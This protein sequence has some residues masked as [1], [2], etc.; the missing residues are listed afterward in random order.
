MHADWVGQGCSMR[1]LRGSD[2]KSG[3][4]RAENESV[5][6]SRGK[7]HKQTSRNCYCSEL[8][9]FPGPALLDDERPLFRAPF[10]CRIARALQLEYGLYHALIHITVTNRSARPR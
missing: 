4:L 3:S 5:Y 10:L 9:L 8:D 2:S 1:R 7:G 6:A